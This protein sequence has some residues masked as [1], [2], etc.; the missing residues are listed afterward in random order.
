[1]FQTHVIKKKSEKCVGTVEIKYFKKRTLHILLVIF[2]GSSFCNK[3]FQ[4][5]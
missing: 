5:S 3:Y 2:L 1:M 4:K